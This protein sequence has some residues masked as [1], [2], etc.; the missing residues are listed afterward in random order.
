MQNNP[1]PLTCTSRLSVWVVPRNQSVTA[2]PF[3]KMLIRKIRPGKKNIGTQPKIVN[4]NPRAPHQ[5]TREERLNTLLNY[6]QVQGQ[7]YSASNLALKG[8]VFVVYFGERMPL[9][10]ENISFDGS[11]WSEQRSSLQARLLFQRPLFPE[12]LTKRCERGN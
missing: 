8:I 4:F 2:K 6:I 11:R 10:K 9:F 3:D 5:R 1:G 7:L 12:I